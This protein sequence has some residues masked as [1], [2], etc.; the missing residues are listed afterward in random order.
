LQCY[1]AMRLA[2]CFLDVLLT[3]FFH[4]N[5]LLKKLFKLSRRIAES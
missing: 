3:R 4:E 1:L 5:A 2:Y